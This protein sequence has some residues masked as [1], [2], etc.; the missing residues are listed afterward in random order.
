MLDAA[1][2]RC[3][4]LAATSG[5][6]KKTTF[7]GDPLTDIVEPILTVMEYDRDERTSRRCMLLRMLNPIVCESI[8]IINWTTV[9]K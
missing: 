6:P 2:N 9:N 3:K 8:S 7:F 4:Q 5:V 1:Y